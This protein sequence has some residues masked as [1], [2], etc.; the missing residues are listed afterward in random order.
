[1]PTPPLSRDVAQRALDA[2]KEHG[3]VTEAAKALGISRGTL[4]AR[5]KRAR[6]M[7]QSYVDGRDAIPHALTYESAWIEWQRFIGQAKDR[8]KGPRTKAKG[9]RQRIVIASDFHIPF[10]DKSYVA[11]LFQREADADLLIL[12]G[13]LQ[14]FFAVSRFIKYQQVPVEREFAEVQLFLEQ[15][16]QAWPEILIV[17]GN[18]DHP[19]FE[20]QLRDRLDPEMCKVVEFLAG[21][22]LSPIALMAR[23]FQ[24]VKLAK[25]TAADANQLLW[26][27]QVGDLLVTHAEKFSRVPGATTR[28]VDEWLTD[29]DGVIDVMPWRV[30]AQGHTHQISAFPWKSNRMLLETGCLCQT[31]GY[32][33]V[34]K[35]G[36]R[37]QRRGWISLEQVNGV[38]QMSS[39]RMTWLDSEKAV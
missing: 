19:R 15:A 39:I 8:Y 31:A 21:G 35:I 17:A 18:H 32:Q 5:V 12:N 33:M 3:T 38:T 6:Q 29:F 11:E 30:L 16:S 27:A 26:M 23:K 37:P 9:T 10:H 24:N 14:D 4:D 1:M 22:N 20:K 28:S 34:A 25:T 36:G 13:D 2:V 7:A